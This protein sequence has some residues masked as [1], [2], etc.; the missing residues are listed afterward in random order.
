MKRLLVCDVR[1]HYRTSLAHLTCRQDRQV[2]RRVCRQP[3]QFQE[4][5]QLRETLIKLP[6]VVILLTVDQNV[7]KI[8]QAQFDNRRWWLE[9]QAVS[10]S[11]WIW[12]WAAMVG[13]VKD[14]VLV[15]ERSCQKWPHI[16]GNHGPTESFH[17]L[18]PRGNKSRVGSTA[19][20]PALTRQI[21]EHRDEIAKWGSG[22]IN[23]LHAG[24]F[25][26]DSTCQTHPDIAICDLGIVMN[27][28]C[29]LRVVQASWWR[30]QCGFQLSLC[31]VVKKCRQ[32]QK[33]RWYRAWGGQGGP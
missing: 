3:F 9:C 28:P 11:K 25:S 26:A 27:C 12:H 22:K 24:A 1:C 33:S 23:L 7:F 20:Q 2:C 17:V 19:G 18:H 4:G 21:G 16:E 10:R 6:H 15:E 32:T 5:A 8:V 14:W 31:F 13:F 30:A 29:W